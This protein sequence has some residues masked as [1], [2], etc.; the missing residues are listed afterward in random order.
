MFAAEWISK[1]EDLP[2]MSGAPTCTLAARA[3]KKRG[4][5]SGCS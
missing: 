5:Q 4:R 2:S 3:P 1:R